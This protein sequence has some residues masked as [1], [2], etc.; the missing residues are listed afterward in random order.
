MVLLLLLAGGGCW[1]RVEIEDRG[2]VLASGLDWAAAKPPPSSLEAG[3][4]TGDRQYR[5]TLQIVEPA[6]M[7]GGQVGGGGGG[8]GG[9]EAPYWNIST[10]SGSIFAAIRELSTRVDRIPNFEHMNVVVIGEELALQGMGDALDVFLR[11]NEVRRRAVVYVAPG[12]ATR[13]LEIK[14]QI[15]SVNAIYLLDLFQHSWKTSRFPARADLNYVKQSLVA[16]D[17]FVLP[18]VVPGKQDA[19]LA[20]GATFKEGRMVGWLGEAEVEGLQWLTGGVRGGE[21]VVPCPWGSAV[22]VYEI[23]TAASYLLPQVEEGQVSFTL[24]VNTEGTF[25]EHQDAHDASDPAYLRDFEDTVGKY[26]EQ[27]VQATLARLQG[28]RADAAGLGAALERRYPRYWE[29]IKERWEDA[30]FPAVK[31]SVDARVNVRRTGLQK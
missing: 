29:S 3:S 10:V 8:S 26:I 13:V 28:Y 16:R 9:Q 7:T 25:A 27:Q 31:V 21:I 4:Y 12:E 22:E 1:D 20:G 24:V 23:N 19:K 17:S 15:A 14:P 2:F 18:R 6:K 30:I 11:D 5:L